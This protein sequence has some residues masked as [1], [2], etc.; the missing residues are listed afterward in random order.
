MFND[1]FFQQFFGDLG[2]MIPK[3]R[4]ERALGS[5][6][7]ISKDGY[8]VTNNHV[9]DGADKIKVTI[10]GSNKEYSATL[11]GTDSES[12]LAVIRI[13]KDNLPTIKFSDSNDISVGDLVFA[14][15]NPFGVGE[16]VTQGIV[17]ALNKSGI[18]INSY[19]NFI[20]TDASINPGNSGGALIDSRGGLVG[21]NTAI[22][23]K[24]GGN[25]GIGFA[26]RF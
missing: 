4:M 21:I 22:I 17:S 14:I 10:P 2:G 11:V 16:S 5:G 13:T 6:V 26:I 20:Q 23:S 15:G 1:P 9:I 8:I 3:E 12:D 18:G 25:H 19:E 7:I 24:T